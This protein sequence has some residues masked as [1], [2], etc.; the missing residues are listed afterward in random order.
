MSDKVVA[1]LA[2]ERDGEYGGEPSRRI[3]LPNIDVRT[4]AQMNQALSYTSLR[5]GFGR[6]GCVM[7]ACIKRNLKYKVAIK[8]VSIAGKGRRAAKEVSILRKIQQFP[9]VVTTFNSFQCD[10]YLYIV[11]EVA[12][13][14]LAEVLHRVRG[15]GLKEDFCALIARHILLALDYLHH[16]KIIHR[17]ICPG[18]I[19]VFTHGICKLGGFGEAC[20]KNRKEAK[21]FFGTPSYMA[22]E[23]RF[24]K[25]DQW[26][27]DR[28]YT[29]TIDIWSLGCVI[30]G[31]QFRHSLAFL[32]H[33]IIYFQNALWV[34][35]SC[36][37]LERTW[38]FIVALVFANPTT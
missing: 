35:P 24:P 7:K 2:A 33:N 16:A 19:L 20:N 1:W 27:R 29:E 18:N 26:G 34:V 15:H 10:D 17:D 37:S 21:G 11:M 32:I 23:V 13:G 9:H 12:L 4:Q 31:N 8:Q 38:T 22:P 36:G 6:Y 30:L 28:Y 5:L 25:L 14:D 3:H